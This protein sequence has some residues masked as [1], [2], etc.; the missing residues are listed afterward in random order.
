LEFFLDKRDVAAQKVESRQS[1][2]A[3]DCEILLGLISTAFAFI[4]EKEI[5]ALCPKTTK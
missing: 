4:R 5:A 1:W 2:M 3:K